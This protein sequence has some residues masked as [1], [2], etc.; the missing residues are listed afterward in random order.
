[1]TALFTGGEDTS[2]SPARGTVN[3]GVDTSTVHFRTAW[4]RCALSITGDANL[5]PLNRLRSP[6]TWA[7]PTDFWLHA[8]FYHSFQAAANALIVLTDASRNPLAAIIGTGVSG[9]FRITD[10]AFSTIA[11][12]AGDAIPPLNLIDLDLHVG[13]AGLITLYAAGVPVLSGTV[14]AAGS[15]VRGFD[16]SAACGGQQTWWSEI[17]ASDSVT[18]GKSLLTMPL[19]ANGNT[20]SWTGSVANV[21]EVIIDDT[22]F[23]S[24]VTANQAEQ[25]T[26]TLASLTGNYGVDALITEARIQV[27][28]TGPQNFE[29]DIRTA[30]G[31]DHTASAGP[32]TR[33]FDNYAQI[34]ATNPHSSAAWVPSDFGAGFNWGIESQ[35]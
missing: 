29:W 30:D 11:T 9:Q 32:P 28:T 27:G 5:P 2:F 22:G 17:I 15:A 21:N 31:S 3:M 12:S 20:T 1:M 14:A 8:W 25:F 26:V 7:A 35:A 13:S 19:A 4:A 24:T 33:S 18:R 34:W 6:N 16:L 23:N 10:G